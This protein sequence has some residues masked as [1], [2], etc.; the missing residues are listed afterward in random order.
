MLIRAPRG[1]ADEPIPLLPGSLVRKAKRTLPTM[2]DVLI[3]DTNHYLIVF[4]DR[5]AAAVAA[6]IASRVAAC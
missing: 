2:R 6:E 4:G 5:E 1:L 3:D